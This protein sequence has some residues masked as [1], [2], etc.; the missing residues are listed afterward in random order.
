MDKYKEIKRKSQEH[1]SGKL[2]EKIPLNNI[3]SSTQ[4]PGCKGRHESLHLRAQSQHA[5]KTILFWPQVPGDLSCSFFF[6]FL[7][8]SM[9]NLGAALAHVLDFSL[10]LTTQFEHANITN[11]V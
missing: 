11:A 8:V 9:G 4:R 10:H 3:K 5:N 1:Y 2:S 6:G 7:L